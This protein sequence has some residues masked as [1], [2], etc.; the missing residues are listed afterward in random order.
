M[1]HYEPIGGKDNYDWC[2]AVPNFPLHKGETITPFPHGGVWW[3]NHK[4]SSVFIDFKD[5]TM[6]IQSHLLHNKAQRTSAINVCVKFIIFAWVCSTSLRKTF[7]WPIW[8]C[9]L[10]YEPHFLCWLTHSIVI[11]IFKF[12]L[13][14]EYPF[15]VI[16]WFYTYSPFTARSD[17]CQPVSALIRERVCQIPERSS[18]RNCR[19]NYVC[20]WNQLSDMAENILPWAVNDI[21]NSLLFATGWIYGF[22]P[23]NLS[24]ALRSC[25]K[26]QRTKVLLCIIPKKVKIVFMWRSNE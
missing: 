14:V 2:K 19:Y 15:C 9:L 11:F 3:F 5:T 20:P 4:G 24:F 13:G 17:K 22:S 18:Q 16:C 21:R 10:S 1:S 8:M 7:M 26:L 6:I 25:T 23:S 12:N